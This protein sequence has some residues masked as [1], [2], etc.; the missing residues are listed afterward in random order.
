MRNAGIW[1]S[2]VSM[3]FAG[4]F[5][6]QSTKVDYDGALGFGPGFFPLWLSIIM[7][8]LSVFYLFSSLKE[9]IHIRK[10]IPEGN[11]WVDFL[12]ILLSMAVFVFLLERVGFVLSGTIC[13]ILLLFRTFKW[14]YT[15]PLSIGI[16]LAIFFIFAKALAIPLPVNALGW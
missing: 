2:I 14:Y 4:T 15:V 7:L 3:A 1:A 12:L 13:L 5:L 6:Y 8:I 16:T 10:L 9:K 11:S